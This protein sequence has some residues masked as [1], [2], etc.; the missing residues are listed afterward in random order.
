MNPDITAFHQTENNFFSLLSFSKSAYSNLTAFATGVN[1]SGL[2]PVIV[3]K[4]NEKFS[5]ELMLCLSLYKQENL[6]WALVLPEYLHT[7]ARENFLC[8]ENLS[9][10]G[11]GVAMV[12]VMADMALPVI[13]SPLIIK[14]MTGGLHEW[15]IPLIEAFESTPEVTAIYTMRH[16]NASEG[17][18]KLFHFSGFIDDTVV[19]SLS[20]SL[21]DDYA[22]IDDVATLPSYQKKGYATQL[23]YSA[24]SY[25]RELQV[26]HCF[27][28]ASDSGLTIYEKMGFNPLFINYYYEKNL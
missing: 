13:E 27:L 23:M 1:A 25:A 4:V 21:V 9:F 17:N 20:L 5:E 16:Q 22:R 24:L 14:A 18:T 11:K 19:C 8:E 6:P 7:K 10:T 3:N 28:E 2:N 26:T 15:S 12:A